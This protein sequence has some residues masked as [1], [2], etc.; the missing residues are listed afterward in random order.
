MP[1]RGCFHRLNSPARVRSIALVPMCSSGGL[2]SITNF[3]ASS[4]SL[5]A[6]FPRTANLR[7]LDDCSRNANRASRGERV[8]RERHEE[9]V[10][11]LV[12]DAD[13]KRPVLNVR[14]IDHQVVGLSD[15]L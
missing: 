1:G 5:N 8:G 15:A 3:P 7:D 10:L 9:R 6:L 14:F 12:E 2:G 4:A 11:S 13:L